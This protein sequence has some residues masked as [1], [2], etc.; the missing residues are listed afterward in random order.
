MR[1]RF[2][3][4]TVT[5]SKLALLAVALLEASCSD[6]DVPRRRPQRAPAEEGLIDSAI[7]PTTRA[8]RLSDVQYDNSVR[9]LLGLD[10]APSTMFNK[11]EPTYDGFDNNSE[12]LV[13]EPIRARDYRMAAENLAAQ[14]ASNA[15]ALNALAPC[16]TPDTTACGK[17][18]VTKF[19][20]RAFRRPLSDP[21]QADYLVLYETGRTLFPD[22]TLHQRGVQVV[23]EAMLQSPH[24]LYRIEL[25]DSPTGNGVARLSS[26]ELATR[27]SYSMWNA[28]PDDALLA[29]AA[30]NELSTADALAE[31]AKV[32]LTDPRAR[33][34]VRDFHAQWFDVARYA[35]IRRDERVYP[36]FVTAELAPVLSQEVGEFVND[37]VFEQR[38]GLNALLTSPVAF[39]NGKTAPLYG[40]TGTFG[41]E[42]QRVELDPGVRPG[43]LTRAGFL[44]SNAHSSSTAPILRG[45]AILK[46]VLC[47]KLGVPP[48]EASASQPPAFSETIRTTREQVTEQTKNSPCNAC[49]QPLINP[50]GF[51]FEH[52]DAVGSWRD[53]EREYPVD[54]T[55]SV[56]LGSGA[57][58]FDGASDFIKQAAQTVEA[59]SCY[60]QQ[61]LRYSYGRSESPA[62]KSVLGTLADRLG[63]QNYGVQDLVVDLTR[64]G[65]FYLRSEGASQ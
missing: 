63:Q 62:D 52:F 50:V 4:A 31:R 5:A 58:E 12:K 33:D 24:F 19:G 61:W 60:A 34:M 35:N 57:L 59:R 41:P 28:P 17:D 48:A 21:E 55:G 8:A 16:A 29:S 11:G 36:T 15:A 42:L 32:M 64:T 44:A 7:A 20:L 38:G 14:V 18:F 51:A 65:S 43:L 49:H 9:W 47:V 2:S 45:V 39:V 40:L 56:R 23:I 26:Y 27:L 22:G 1:V 3:L 54:A 6:A 25:N 13:V 30:K 37:V 46:K 10:V 53:A